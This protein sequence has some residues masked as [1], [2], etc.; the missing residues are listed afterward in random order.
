MLEIALNLS[1][2]LLPLAISWRQKEGMD[3]F[4]IKL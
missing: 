1:S 3:V 2:F 4:R